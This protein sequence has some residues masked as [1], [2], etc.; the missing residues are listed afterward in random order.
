MMKIQFLKGSDY[1][2]IAR[3]MRYLLVIDTVDIN[4]E[5][6]AVQQQQGDI[7]PIFKLK[8]QN[9]II[10]MCGGYVNDEQLA[11][12]I[13]SH[14]NNLNRIVTGDTSYSVAEKIRHVLINDICYNSFDGCNHMFME[15]SNEIVSIDP[16]T[17]TYS[18]GELVDIWYDSI[19]ELACCLVQ[20][21]ED[22]NKAKDQKQEHLNCPYCGT[23]MEPIDSECS[24]LMAE[25]VGFDSIMS[26]DAFDAVTEYHCTNEDCSKT[27][28]VPK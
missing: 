16:D 18:F 7:E 11:K 25:R 17:Q 10:P 28:F 22:S 4:G 1:E 3:A 9:C 27:V 26:G 5:K 19:E 20:H 12:E 8:S 2:Q 13:Y 21:F 6:F 23:V 24:V 15:G 14:L